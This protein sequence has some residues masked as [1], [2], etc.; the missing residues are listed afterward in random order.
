MSVV[1]E[2]LDLVEL[3]QSTLRICGADAVTAAASC[4][5]LMQKR[6]GRGSD[7]IIGE[8]IRLPV[9]ASARAIPDGTYTIGIR[10]HHITPQAR[11]P[12]QGLP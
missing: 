8:T 2:V 9:G 12:G 1:S 10:P 11:K 5:Q 3:L 6:E 4:R 7:V